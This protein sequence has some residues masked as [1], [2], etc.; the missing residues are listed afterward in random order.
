MLK[1][2]LAAL[3]TALL[4]AGLSVVAVAVPASATAYPPTGS[5][6]NDADNWEVLE[7]EVCTKIDESVAPPYILPAPP[8]GFEW[9]KIITKAGSGDAANTIHVAGTGTAANTVYHEELVEGTAVQ[10]ATKDSISHLILCATP[11]PFTWDW[12]YADPT[13][14]ALTVSYPVNIPSG[15]ANDVN[16]RIV[17]GAGYSQTITLNFHNNTGT[18]SGTK[19]FTYSSHPNWPANIGPYKVVWTQVG[20]TNYHWQGEVTCGT[21]YDASAEVTFT[22]PTCDAGQDIALGAIANATWGDLDIDAEGNYSVTATANEGHLF[23]GGLATKTFS[24]TLLGPDTSQCE[25]DLECLPRSAVSYTYVPATNSGV[26]TVVNPNPSKYS[27]ELCQGFW[28]TAT[29]WKY[30]TTT[31]WPQIRDVV[32]KLPKITSVGTYPYVAAVQ[33]GQGDIYASF[34]AQPDPTEWLYGPSNPFPETFLHNMGFTGPSPTWTQT[35]PGCNQIPVEPPVPHAI[36]ECGVYGS[37]DIPADTE[38]VTYTL[39]GN[40]QTGI[41]TVTATAVTPYVLSGYPAGGWTF[42][43]GEYTDCE[44]TL[45]IDYVRDCAV[46]PTNTWRVYNTGEDTVVVTYGSGQTHQATPGYSIFE[47][48]RADETMQISWGQ[49]GSGIAPGT[50][51][52]TAG[53]DYTGDDEPCYTEPDVSHVV[54]VCVYD[55]NANPADRALSITYDN[56]AS[57]VAVTFSLVGF[58]GVYDRTVAAGETYTFSAPNVT[59]AGGSYT[60]TAAGEEFTFSVPE[61]ET[62]D[63]PEPKT[64]DEVVPVYD[65]ESAEAT[66]TTTTYTTDWVFNPTT[67]TWEEGEEVAGTP[68]VTT[69]PM[70]PEEIAEEVCLVV[71]SDP[72]ASTCEANAETQFTSWIR[73]ELNDNIEYR[74]DGEL[75]TSE[76]TEVTPGEH[77]VVATALNGYTLQ[78]AQPEPDDWTDTTHTWTFTAVDSA[79]ECGPTLEGSFATGVCEGDAPWIDWSVAMS[80]PYNRATSHHAYLV[81]TD[82]TNTETLDLGE[83]VYNDATGKWELSDQTLWPGASVDAEG[84]ATGWPGWEQLEDGTWQETTGNFAWTR[85]TSSATFVVNPELAIDLTYPDATPECSDPDDNPTLA[86]VLPEFS[87]TPLT[88]TAAGSY[89]IG[90]EFGAVSWTVNGVPTAAGTYQ[91]KT[92]G[93]VTLEATP[94]NPDDS[95]DDAWVD[96]PVVLAFAFPDGSCTTL[97]ALTGAATSAGIVWAAAL[98]ALTGVGILLMRRKTT[99]Q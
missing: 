25:P 96:E 1:K 15:Q 34:L 66:V 52:A 26:I 68:V 72:E 90:A 22:T 79:T 45:T 98:V 71:A 65:C 31:K 43:L 99:A 16:I 46:D 49:T 77:T 86:Q 61:C 28:V 23:P 97:L 9:S 84:N 81:I 87:S 89:T 80:D 18:W 8:T 64:R 30:T 42:D 53:L 73:V 70:T 78:G 14:T 47:T 40:G 11:I 19:V 41:N 56:T 12:E 63:K 17:Y 92:P 95:F 74:I 55:E 85:D 67:L 37:I 21:P 60:V 50:A 7:G 24:G 36:T 3:T 91:V 57:S 48:P 20:G 75:V 10:H 76:Y 62:Y 51:S 59:P 88:C 29:S 58:G 2:I 13:C 69:R 5:A 94:T 54:G 32:Q 39:T 27:N 38:Y 93:T 6:A 4:A 83:L 82:G 44:L 33:C 35:E